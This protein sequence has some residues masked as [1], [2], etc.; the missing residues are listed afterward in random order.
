MLVCYFSVAICVYI[1][2]LQVA[3][4][5]NFSGPLPHK[6]RANGMSA[7][8]GYISCLGMCIVANFQVT[9]L[10]QVHYIGAAL[11]FFIGTIYFV[12][13]VTEFIKNNPYFFY[14]PFIKLNFTYGGIK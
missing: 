8:L 2:Q 13:Q 7:V 12:F 6:L 14:S 10:W 3:K 9:N 5:T 11:C 4:F 1:R